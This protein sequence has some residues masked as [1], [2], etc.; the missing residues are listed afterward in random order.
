MSSAMLTPAQAAALRRAR[1]LAAELT[2][3]TAA[4]RAALREEPAAI[5][6]PGLEPGEL[7]AAFTAARGEKARRRPRELFGGAGT[8]VDSPA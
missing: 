5:A 1:E 6:E 4:V 3:L 8:P 2:H 7:R